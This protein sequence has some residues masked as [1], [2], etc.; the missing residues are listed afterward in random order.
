MDPI[1][2]AVVA[3]AAA[4]LG[5][6][7][8][9][10]IVD[11]YAALKRLLVERAGEDS[12]VIRAVDGIEARPDSAARRTVLEEE[13]AA[14]PSLGED[15]EVTSAAERVLSAIREHAPSASVT[16]ADAGITAG[17]DVRQ[18]A[19]RDAAGRDLSYRHGHA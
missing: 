15:A 11:A 6:V 13:V 10:A 5:S 8:Q 19:G 16:A 1:T 12:E 9:S 3:A 14:L 18:T 7:A 4:G 17:G 2:A